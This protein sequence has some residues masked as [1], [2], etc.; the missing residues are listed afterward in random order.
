M[1]VLKSGEEEILMKIE[2][3]KNTIVLFD[4][5]FAMNGDT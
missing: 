3:I 4:N 1:S 5:S 2:I